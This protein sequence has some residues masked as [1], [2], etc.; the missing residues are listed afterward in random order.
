MELVGEDFSVVD[1]IPNDKF[2]VALGDTLEDG[3]KFSVL[4]CGASRD[5]RLLG[6]ETL[7]VTRKR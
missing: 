7:P 4:G 2:K 6:F 5:L 3:S 1:F